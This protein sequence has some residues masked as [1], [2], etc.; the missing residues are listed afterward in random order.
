MTPHEA[1]ATLYLDDVDEEPLQVAAVCLDGLT[2]SQFAAVAVACLQR[3][4]VKL[5]TGTFYTGRKASVYGRAMA[6]RK[7]FSVWW[8]GGL[9]GRG[10]L[11][12]TPEGRWMS[13]R[14][15]GQD[16]SLRLVR[17]YIELSD[18]DVGASI[19]Q[20]LANRM[21]SLRRGIPQRYRGSA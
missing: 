10:E 18:T 8:F 3:S 12:I 21:D 2:A 5:E 14:W 16:Y 6:R 4:S 7:A 1:F 15:S 13:S 11:G 19:Q 17:S 9:A 20:R